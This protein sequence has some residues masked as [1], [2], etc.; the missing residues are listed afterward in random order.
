MTCILVRTDL[1]PYGIECLRIVG[2]DHHGDLTPL[3]GPNKIFPNT[4][5]NSCGGLSFPEARDAWE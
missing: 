4:E 3:H 5:Q 1:K 2:H